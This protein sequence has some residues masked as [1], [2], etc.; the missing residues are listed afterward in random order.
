MKNIAVYIEG[1]LIEEV[2]RN[3]M[4]GYRQYEVE[5]LESE[6]MYRQRISLLRNYWSNLMRK[7]IDN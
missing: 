1:F 2:N 7:I 4:L 5:C 3:T 6:M